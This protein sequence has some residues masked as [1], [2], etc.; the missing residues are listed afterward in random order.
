MTKSPEVVIIHETIAKSWLR[1]LSTFTLFVALIGLGVLL[2]SA[3]MQWIGAIIGF[4]TI[5]I[6][7]S[8]THKS[9]R[10]T[11]AQ[12]RQFLDELEDA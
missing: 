8:G 5:V 9:S 7:A 1:D 3:A 11:I 12:A 6:R 10:K 2:G 4:I